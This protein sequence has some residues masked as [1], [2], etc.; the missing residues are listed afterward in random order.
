M[1]YDYDLWIQICDLSIMFYVYRLRLSFTINA[2]EH[3]LW[4]MRYV[5]W[6]WTMTYDICFMIKLCFVY[7][8]DYDIKKYFPNPASSRSLFVIASRDSSCTS[9][10]IDYPQEVYFD[11]R[12]L[13]PYLR[14][15]R[16]HWVGFTPRSRYW[17]DFPWSKFYVRNF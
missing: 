7:D 3:V 12:S 9:W 15:A 17:W 8:T 4:F 1:K 13:I 6:L 14:G 10:G 5:L 2:Y 11:S 16:S